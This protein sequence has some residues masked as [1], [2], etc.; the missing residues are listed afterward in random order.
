M[1]ALPPTLIAGGKSLLT[2]KDLARIFV[3][4][5]LPK[6]K[7]HLKYLGIENI[8]KQHEIGVHIEDD[9]L[10]NAQNDYHY[11]GYNNNRKNDYRS[12]S[13]AGEVN[14]LEASHKPF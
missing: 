12:T 6:Y 9:L 10:T 2:D 8:T 7:T 13:K 5:F 4:N 11:K 14:L 3:N 1:K